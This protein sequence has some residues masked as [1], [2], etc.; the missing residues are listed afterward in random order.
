MTGLRRSTRALNRRV[1]CLLAALGGF[2]MILSP[3][4]PQGG[5]PLVRFRMFGPGS[6]FNTVYELRT[7]AILETRRYALGGEPIETRQLSLELVDDDRYRDLLEGSGYFTADPQDLSQPQVQNKLTALMDL[8][9][10]KIEV[11]RE[12][13]QPI[14]IEIPDRYVGEFF[15]ELATVPYVSAAWQLLAEFQAAWNASQRVDP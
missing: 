5:T 15:P 14:T 1:P 10:W 7:D 9:Y 4:A 3:L 11:F 6:V 12:G 2:V 8:P 13:S